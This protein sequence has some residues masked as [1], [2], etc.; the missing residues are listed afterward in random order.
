MGLDRSPEL[1]EGPGRTQNRAYGDRGDLRDGQD[2]YKVH[3]I[4]S[5]LKGVVNE[6][7]GGFEFADEYPP[8][9]SYSVFSRLEAGPR[10]SL[11]L[12]VCAVY[13]ITIGLDLLDLRAFAEDLREISGPFEGGGG[14]VTNPG[15]THAYVQHRLASPIGEMTAYLSG[16]WITDSRE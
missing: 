2:G 10:M 3:G 16:E 4:T 15:F 8:P 13:T 9:A 11:R 14:M 7:S 6:V 12:S 5:F 1:D